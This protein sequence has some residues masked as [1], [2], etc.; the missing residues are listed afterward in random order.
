VCL[1]YNS[2]HNLDNKFERVLSITGEGKVKPVREVKVLKMYILYHFIPLHTQ[3]I[4]EFVFRILN[5]E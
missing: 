1:I 3:D 2:F 4:A 5:E